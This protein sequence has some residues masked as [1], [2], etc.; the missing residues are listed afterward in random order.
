MILGI[1]EKNR[2]EAEMRTLASLPEDNPNPVIR[3]SKDGH[4]LYANRPG[5]TMLD[6]LGGRDNSP[7]PPI[8]K[9]AVFRVLSENVKSDL[10]LTGP[11]EKIFLFT[12]Y[13]NVPE[14]YVNL[15][16]SD[17]TGLKQ[18]EQKLAQEQDNLRSI[19]DAANI[20][21]LL[22]DQD[23]TINR[24]NRTLSDWADKKESAM[25]GIRP[26]NALGCLNIAGDKAALCGQTKHCGVCPIR[27]TFES[28]LRTGEP[29]HGVE[30]E[31]T[32]VVNGKSAYFWFELSADPVIVDGRRQV[33]LA[34]NDITERKVAE[35]AFLESRKDLNRAQAVAHIGSWRLDI[36]KNELVW[37]DENYRIFGVSPDTILTY[38]TFLA[39]VH[40]ADREYVDKKWT[41][42]LRGAPYEIE[43]RIIAGDEIKWVREK[44]ELEFDHQGTLLG[45]FGTTQDITARKRIQEALRRSEEKYKTLAEASPDCIKLFDRD[46]HLLYINK[47][48]LEEHRLKDVTEAMNWDYFSC[49][50]EKDRRKFRDGFEKALKGE[51]NTIEIEHT[52]EGSIRDFCLETMVPVKNQKG[53]VEAVY[54]VSRDI[55]EFKKIDRAKTEFVSLASHQLRTPLTSAGFALEL[56][57]REFA[58]KMGP[59]QR[60]YLKNAHQDLSFMTDLVNRLLNISRIEMGTF[61]DDPQKIKLEEFMD[62]VVDN[63]SILAKKKNQKIIKEYA[64]ALP[65][66]VTV[67]PNILHNVLQNLISNAVKYTPENGRI[68]VSAAGKDAGIVIGVSDT[69]PGIPPEM[70]AKVF[71]KLYKAHE[72]LK[73]ESESSGLGLYIAKL[74]IEEL[75]G[76]IW[77]ETKKDEGT[78]F[79]IYLPL[80]AKKDNG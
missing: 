32:L 56:L 11:S 73:T 12:L 16:G 72:L 25:V 68:T 21:L 52:S 35:V 79:F 54:G 57:L 64:V 74:F 23:G 18:A 40:P 6:A 78:T 3:A 5:R 77:L 51:M 67:D 8:L 58:D 61:T 36:K 31:T 44:A 63:L 19:F 70:Q 9:E 62:G 47:A 37:S 69:G 75:G 41:A 10:E 65:E 38:E 49:V 1:S 4:V 59:E 15:Y 22:I 39:F 2:I 14:N 48:G 45:G 42:A 33:I 50:V 27:R 29:V 26:G 76:R 13:P 34:M 53:E 20:S 46:G 55:S 43:H 60:D 28:V 17:I 71:T 66:F 80:E 7:L 24:V 30:A